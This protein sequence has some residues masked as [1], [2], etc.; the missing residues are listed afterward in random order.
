MFGHLEF[1][2]RPLCGAGRG[3]VERRRV[4]Q[5]VGKTQQVKINTGPSASRAA[6]CCRLRMTTLA[7]RLCRSLH[8]LTEQRIG[9]LSVFE[10]HQIIRLVEVYRA[11]IRR[12]DKV[13][14]VDG[15]RCLDIGFEEIVIGQR[16]VL[17][18]L[19]SYPLTISSQGTS[20]PV[21]IINA[22]ISNAREIAPVEQVEI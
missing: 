11:D 6:K 5:L 18:L 14:N 22:S 7:I 4:A 10:R 1:L 16:N 17:S 13:K 9:T 3:H 20:R 15:L 2:I 12:I 19:Y 21:F 8:D